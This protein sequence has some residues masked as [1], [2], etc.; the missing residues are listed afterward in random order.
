MIGCLNRLEVYE[1]MLRM[2]KVGRF[3]IVEN[4]LRNMMKTEANAIAEFETEMAKRFG[5]KTV[6][7][8]VKF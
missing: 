8:D 3:N 5:A 6:E 1:Q 4:M 2:L 7:E